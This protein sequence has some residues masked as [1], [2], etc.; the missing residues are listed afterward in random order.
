M[1]VLSG[2][3]V[4]GVDTAGHAPAIRDMD[5][6][7]QDGGAWLFALTSL[8]GTLSVYRLDGAGGP[9]LA[10]AHALS[11]SLGY[12]PDPQLEVVATAS[13]LLALP[14]GFGNTSAG[15]TT[16]L[17]GGTS[18]SPVSY[19]STASAPP[20]F[21]EAASI[22]VGD[23]TFVF[24]ATATAGQIATVRVGADG[25]FSTG[26]TR[27]LPTSSTEAISALATATTT[28]GPIMVAATAGN[29]PGLHLYTIGAGG[30]L[31]LGASLPQIS[32]LGLTWVSKVMAVQSAGGPTFVLAAGAGSSSLAVFQW[33]GGQLI[34]VDHVLDTRDSRF[35]G[36]CVLEVAEVDGIVYVLAGGTDDGISLLTLLPDGRLLHLATLEDTL[37]M[38]LDSGGSAALRVSGRVLQVY[39]AGGDAEGITRLDFSLGSAGVRTIGGAGVVAGSGGS[40]LLMAGT[41]TTELS[42]GAGDDILYSAGRDITL[43]GGAGADVFALAPVAGTLRVVDFTPGVDRIDLSLFPMLRS[44]DQITFQSTASGVTMTIGATRIEITSGTGTPLSAADFRDADLIPFDRLTGLQTQ[45]QFQTTDIADVFVGGQDPA[46][47]SGGGGDDSLTGGGANDTFHGDAGYDVILGM[48]GADYLTGGADDDTLVGDDGADTLFGGTGRD[49]LQGGRDDDAI[50]GGDGDDMLSGAN[51]NDLLD[52]GA[53]NDM[54]YGG[55]AEDRLYGNVGFDTLFGGSGNDLLYGGLQADSVQGDD[56]NDTLFGEQ[57]FDV[58]SGNAGNDFLDGG[59]DEDWIFGGWNNDTIYGGEGNDWLFGG[60]GFDTIHG[61]LGNDQ[62]RGEAN[63]DYLNGNDG[64]DTIFGNDGFDVISGNNGNDVLY[65]GNDEDWMFGGWDNDLVDGG[66]GDDFIFCGLGNDTAHGQDG[67]DQL[68]GEWGDDVLYGGLGNDSLRAGGGHD[69]LFGGAGADRFILAQGGRDVIRDFAPTQGGEVIVLSD[70]GLTGGWSQLRD[71]HMMTTA[72]GVLIDLGSGN[73]VLLSGVAISD[74]SSDDFVF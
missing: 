6:A 15:V 10:S 40:D 19:G 14:F 32:G 8:N 67:N 44:M 48:G 51:G 17:S 68:S 61:G 2:V 41:G 50:Y 29:Q 66:S 57:G 23:D 1:V 9:A 42:G 62:I 38:T 69:T 46:E 73:S 49:E 28:S 53:N 24:G 74:L 64:A 63:A 21:L 33:V 18:L 26:A 59:G 11:N 54:A 16:L 22:R 35:A 31:T 34:A 65:G 71:S 12:L 45:L 20:D 58:L 36:A 52:G 60:I 72:D 13:G 47:I 37:S 25:H 55:A 5:I 39:I 70:M 30:A 7:V 3:T 4:F 56:G 27:S 43:R